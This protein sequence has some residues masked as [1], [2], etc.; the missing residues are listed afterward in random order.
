MDDKYLSTASS[1]MHV[2]KTFA[3]FWN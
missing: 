1:H 2:D 3:L